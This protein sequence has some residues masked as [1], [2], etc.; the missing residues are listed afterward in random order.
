MCKC[1]YR[2]TRLLIINTRLIMLISNS[3]GFIG[4][5]P[6]NRPWKL[7]H[8]GG[9]TRWFYV[10]LSQGI[11]TDYVI[12][13]VTS[14]LRQ[15]PISRCFFYNVKDPGPQ[16]PVPCNYSVIVITNAYC[17]ITWKL[18]RLELSYPTTGFPPWETLIYGIARRAKERGMKR[19]HV[20]VIR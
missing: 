2:N 17:R 8:R 6:L 3:A 18:S 4:V 10:P 9:I 15:P 1:A 11:I 7:R 14:R 19:A 13:G 20:C 16:S 5:P 12:R